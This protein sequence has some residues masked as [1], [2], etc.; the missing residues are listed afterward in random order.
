LVVQFVVTHG[1]VML[2]SE[3]SDLHIVW[4]TSTW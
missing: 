2:Y 4:F 3:W 1:S